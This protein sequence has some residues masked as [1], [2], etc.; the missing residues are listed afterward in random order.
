MLTLP[1]V[2]V[3]MIKQ[4]SPGLEIQHAVSPKEWSTVVSVSHNRRIIQC[5]AFLWLLCIPI[6]AHAGIA[7]DIRVTLGSR[8]T[9]FASDAALEQFS[10]KPSIFVAHEENGRTWHR[11][12][13]IIKPS[14]F[15]A[16][17]IICEWTLSKV[18]K[19]SYSLWIQTD[20]QME[21]EDITRIDRTLVVEGPVLSTLIKKPQ[22]NRFV[23]T[24]RFFGVRPPAVSLTYNETSGSENPV[25]RY[26]TA[27]RPLAYPNGDGE[28]GSSCMDVD[29]GESKVELILPADLPEMG[30][31]TIVLKNRI[32]R[33]TKVYDRG[34]RYGA[35]LTMAV[36]PE[37]AG[38]T[39]PPESE[40]TQVNTERPVPVIA[41]P[42]M[43]YHF[44]RWEGTENAVI[45]DKVSAK[46]N[47][48]ILWDAVVT[49]YFEKNPS[50]IEFDGIGFAAGVRYR[51]PESGKTFS[52]ASL[53][54]NPARDNSTPTSEIRYRVYRGVADDIAAVFQEHNLATIV[55]GDTGAVI[56][57][58]LSSDVNYFLV[59]AEDGEGNR[60]RHHRLTR[61]T[62]HDVD[63]EIVPK[64]L[65]ETVSSE[66]HFDAFGTIYFAGDYSA[67]LHT[68]DVVLLD[69]G[70]WK[71]LRVIHQ[72]VVQEDVTYLDSRNATFDAVIAS[73]ILET[74]TRLPEIN[75][76]ITGGSEA[77]SPDNVT[78]NCSA[79]FAPIIKTRAEYVAGALESVSVTLEGTFQLKG[80]LD[81]LFSGE[82]VSWE[83]PELIKKL[84]VYKY[85]LGI[86]P[87]LQE[88][89]VVL[90]G[91]MQI[92]GPKGEHMS[93][94]LDIE[95][96][97][98]LTL[99]WDGQRGWSKKDES[100]TMTCSMPCRPEGPGDI[101]LELIIGP[102]LKTSLNHSPAHEYRL[103]P[104]VGVWA[105][106]IDKTTGAEFQK[107]D[108]TASAKASA[109][110]S[111]GLFS[112][113]LANTWKEE[114]IGNG[115]RQTLFS[116]PYM[117]DL[118]NDNMFVSHE[119]DIIISWK[120]GKNN[121]VLRENKADI[122]WTTTLN[123]IE[124]PYL[125]LSGDPYYE[126]AYDIWHQDACFLP[127]RLGKYQI[128][129][130][131]KGDGFLGNLGM[132][133]DVSIMTVDLP[134]GPQNSFQ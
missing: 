32:G 76:T 113:D 101:D 128:H 71:V 121:A 21:A 85:A 124:Y 30:A 8:F 79:T 18:P 105:T 41:D 103:T 55:T 63:F 111:Y 118:K 91:Y 12:L 97:I 34:Q 56:E 106:K 89:E 112:Q 6:L 20:S 122:R 95:K 88:M 129:V 61:V 125:S 110:I 16:S 134:S 69:M 50:E 42:A 130:M 86:I 54:W 68:G 115:D 96:Q 126:E 4:C 60:N 39:D 93:A 2:S 48:D 47:I 131:M 90:D 83:K 13:K 117:Y 84:S 44:V 23:L 67:S 15:P 24:G 116:L 133:S 49:A 107:F 40:T 14:Q 72:V 36:H 58:P 70:Y 82:Y 94:D 52:E 29:T 1:S 102:R 53:S 78:L 80:E 123:G 17:H 108:L 11:R 74:E 127:R 37:N 7:G 87:V 31:Y 114:W 46:T 33:D 3:N 77:E 35:N 43:D 65:S 109:E 132:I 75:G 19:G 64:D 57:V 5:L 26:C 27:L 73:G 62:Q 98:A 66:I 9:I 100:Q 120:E 59:V 45:P 25:R 38:N 81:V 28:A 10:E 22:E 92:K 51:D 104:Q 119:Q 99:K